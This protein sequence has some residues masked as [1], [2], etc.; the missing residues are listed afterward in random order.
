MLVTLEVIVGD[1]VEDM[2]GLSVKDDDT[3]L[4]DEVDVVIVFVGVCVG[5]FV[6]GL[7]AARNEV[8]TKMV[9]NCNCRH[10]AISIV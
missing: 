1:Q 4:D 3:L 2:E 9:N 5:V 6:F 10:S 7:A 8:S